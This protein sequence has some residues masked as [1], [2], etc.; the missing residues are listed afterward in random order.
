MKINTDLQANIL[1]IARLI[2]WCKSCSLC[3]KMKIFWVSWQLCSLASIFFLNWKALK[4][5]DKKKIIEYKEDN[6]YIN[7]SKYLHTT[8]WLYTFYT[9]FLLLVTLHNP[10][11]QICFINIML[12]LLGKWSHLWLS[13][14]SGDDILR[15]SMYNN[16]ISY[17]VNGWW[18]FHKHGII[19]KGLSDKNNPP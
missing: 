12:T 13:S 18:D 6:A 14:P 1:K 11:H 3:N 5:F 19:L 9:N 17:L 8:F 2:F 15:Y 16:H 10:S 7:F 4:Y